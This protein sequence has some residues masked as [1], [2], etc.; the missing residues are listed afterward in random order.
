MGLLEHKTA[1]ITGGSTGIGLATAKR[2]IAEGATRVFIT[3]RRQP[4]LDHAVAEL[5]PRAVAV[6]GDAG[7]SHDVDR[8]YSAV[9]QADNGVDVIMANA[10][11]TRV[12]RLGEI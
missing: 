12:A 10:G 2:F 4:E 1:V 11:T 8:L 6:R 5:G 7:S 9:R 3:G